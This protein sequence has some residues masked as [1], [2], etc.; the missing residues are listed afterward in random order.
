MSTKP[1]SAL[2]LCSLFAPLQAKEQDGA[3]LALF[4]S[5]VRPILIERC[6]EC[7]SHEKKIK[8]GLAL[9]TRADW[10][11]GG[12]S[13]PA[14]VPGKPAESLL[15]K[16]VSWEDHDLQMPPKRKLSEAEIKALTDWIQA[17]AADPRT[18]TAERK[19][20]SGAM[21]VEAGRKFWSYAPIQEASVPDV[22]DKSWP[23]G[24]IDRFV[25]AGLEEQNLKPG[26]DASPEVLARRAAYVLT[27]LP[28][29]VAQIEASQKAAG[30]RREVLRQLS[31]NLLGSKQFG[32]TWGRHWLDL[33]RFAESSGGGR[34]LLFKDAW[35]YRDYVIESLNSDRPMSQMIREQIAGDLL[36]ATS[37]AERTRRIVATGFLALGP[38]IYE[39]QD[40]QRLRFDIIDEQIET[41]G[42]A[43]LG[44]TVSCAR[45]HDHKFDPITQRDYYALAGVFASTRTLVNYKDN[46]ARWIDAPLPLPSKEEKK[47]AALENRLTTLE[48]DLKTKKNKLAKL[49][50]QF[51]GIASKQD[52][53]LPLKDLPGVVLDDEA[54][55]ANGMWKHST[56]S[57]HYFGNGYLHDDGKEKG[58]KTLTFTPKLP[59]SGKYEVRLA[60]PA[61]AGRSTKVPVHIFHAMGDSTVYVNQSKEPDIA[62][63]FV[64]LGVYQFE[65]DGD[66]YVIVSNEGTKGF[67]CADVVQFLPEGASDQIVDDKAGSKA[68]QSLQ[69]EVTT[70]ETGIR[71]L[72][73]KREGR[74]L[75]MSIREEDTIG[76][77]Q[78]CIR[79]DVHQRGAVVPR[80]F[81]SVAWDGKTR[82]PASQ[83]GRLELADW[84]VSPHNPLTARVMANRIWA[85]MFGHGLVRTVDNFGT[86]GEP[87]SHPALLDY[88]ARRLMEQKWSTKDLIREIMASRTWQLAVGKNSRDSDNRW[89]SHASRRRLDAEQ[90][91]DSI[92]AISDTLDTTIG[93][94]N[95]AGA[96]TFASDSFDA[97]AIEFD[98]KFTDT[99]RSVYTPAFRNNRLELFEAFDFGDI[100]TS[101]GQRYASTVAPQALYFMNHP[102]VIEQATHAAVQAAVSSSDDKQ[103]ITHVFLRSLGREPYDKELA[104]C[105]HSLHRAASDTE[106][107]QSAWSMIFQSIFGCIDF[108][109]LD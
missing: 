105:L 11:A 104:A 94:P 74:P 109:Y 8:G 92:L 43:F 62:G 98:Y 33:A 106:A 16:A 87:P 85:W 17:G 31:E 50:D 15:M 65:K 100:N 64:S 58:A 7:H 57:R 34:T 55:Q 35:R 23:Y 63:R 102:F 20:T 4:E 101:Q 26:P 6:L 25:L 22:K 24:S 61:L 78:I 53:P 52:Q 32:E 36:P 37:T 12:D 70:L 108:R 99:R 81:L 42:K 72:K 5:K 97:S 80:G 46:V 88:L 14:I 39:E 29:T 75:A 27:G 84:L 1:L 28:P 90:I 103:Q 45:C 91:R 73:D 82:M 2:I 67:V 38:T 89:L 79:G 19:K 96:K 49:K 10:A 9:D 56:H 44:Q 18:S 21:S 107:R 41:I 71:E 40:K 95:I 51:T 60:Y 86:T 48:T 66:S 59:A 76:D 69:G 47:F 77:T 68:I 54:A 30:D 3:S 93:G 83:S 13:G